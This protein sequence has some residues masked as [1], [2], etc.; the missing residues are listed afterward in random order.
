MLRPGRI[1][2]GRAARARSWLSCLPAAATD[3][4][5]AAVMP[6]E[7]PGGLLLI[8]LG[9]RDPDHFTPDMGTLFI[10]LPR[11]CPRP[12]AASRSAPREPYHQAPGPAPPG[13][14]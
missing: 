5:S 11:R 2:C 9:S 14:A 13:A 8:A 6:V 1:V 7:V 10:A 12:H 3:V 4:A